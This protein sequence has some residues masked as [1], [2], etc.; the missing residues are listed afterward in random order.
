MGERNEYDEIKEMARAVHL[1]FRE[2]KQQREIAKALNVSTSTVSR[3]VKR[4]YDQGWVKIDFELPKLPLLGARLI[5]KFGLRDAQVL[6]AGEPS[7]LKRDLSVATARYFERT[8]GDR[9]SVG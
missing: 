2:Q 6:P 1:Y 7:E 3:L 4:A 8:V 9:A 5:E